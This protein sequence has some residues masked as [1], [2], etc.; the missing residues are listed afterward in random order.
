[1]RLC[2]TTAHTFVQPDLD[3]RVAL[4]AYVRQTPMQNDVADS[5]E[6]SESLKQERTSQKVQPKH[7]LDGHPRCQKDP[8]C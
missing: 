2:H 8:L 1:M 5:P 3:S 7:Q 6:P 4:H